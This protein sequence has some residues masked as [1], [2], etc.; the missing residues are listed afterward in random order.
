[1]ADTNVKKVRISSSDLPPFGAVEE[2]YTVRYRVVSEDRNRTSAWS[3]FYFLPKP[4]TLVLDQIFINDPVYI[5]SVGAS[6]SQLNL[7]WEQQADSNITQY[8]V[9]LK[10][11]AEGQNIADVPWSLAGTVTNTILSILV[12]AS[13]E[14]ADAVVQIPTPAKGYNKDLVLYRI[15]TNPDETFPNG[16]PTSV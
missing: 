4:N 9:Y 13:A 15:P 11:A 5:T 7:V 16:V 2:G 8:D 10:F 6:R 3:P 12:P 14:T 1:M